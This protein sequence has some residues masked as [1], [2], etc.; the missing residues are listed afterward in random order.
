MERAHE[1]ELRQ[2]RGRMG[3]AEEIRGQLPQLRKE[4]ESDREEIRRQGVENRQLKEQLNK[5]IQEN[6]K[7]FEDL[8]R[9]EVGWKQTKAAFSAA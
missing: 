9:A 2:I 5:W 1:T 4:R 3:E 6:N 7:L 8:N